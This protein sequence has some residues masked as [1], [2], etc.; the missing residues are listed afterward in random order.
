MS[1]GRLARGAVKASCSVGGAA[2]LRCY[3]AVIASSCSCRGRETG[4]GGERLLV[5]RA[6]PSGRL[7]DLFSGD[8]AAVIC[9]YVSVEGQE[10]AKKA[11]GSPDLLRLRNSP[12]YGR[13]SSAAVGP[14]AA[15]TKPPS[16]GSPAPA[17]AA[18]A[19]TPG[20]SKEP[21]RLPRPANSPRVTA[22]ACADAGAPAAA[23]AG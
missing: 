7:S 8:V 17:P 4:G 16:R 15:A 22:A 18:R 12:A 3:R 21:Q 14:S 10:A 5:R 19:R 20:G 11:G 23:R 1:Q 13:R 2:T 6:A 9:G